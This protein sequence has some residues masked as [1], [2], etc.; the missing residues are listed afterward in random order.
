MQMLE[1]QTT[2]DH[3]YYLVEQRDQFQL[4]NRYLIFTADQHMAPLEE[5]GEFEEDNSCLERVCCL[6]NRSFRLD[7]H[8][9][10][11]QWSMGVCPVRFCCWE[12]G[13]SPPELVVT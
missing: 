5:A 4:R 13:C 2:A 10:G 11:D 3:E 6:A 9:K 8:F 7:C 12:L 1:L